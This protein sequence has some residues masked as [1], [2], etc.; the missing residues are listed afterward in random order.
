MIE[1]FMLSHSDL[2][3]RTSRDCKHFTADEEAL[4]QI[5]SYS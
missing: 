2:L 4:E 3:K 1:S 5:N